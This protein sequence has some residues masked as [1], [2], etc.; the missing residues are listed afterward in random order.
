MLELLHTGNIK[1]LPKTNEVG[2]KAYN[3]FWMHQNKL[4]VP[5]FTV[6]TTSMVHKIVAPLKQELNSLFDKVELNSGKEL[7][8]ILQGFRAQILNLSIPDFITNDIA[9]NCNALFGENFRISVRSSAPI[10]DGENSSFAGQFDTYLNVSSQEINTSILRCIASFWNLSVITYRKSKNIFTSQFEFA[11]ILQEMIDSSSSGVAFSVNQHQNMADALIVAG[12]G[13]GEGVVTDK[14]DTDTYKVDRQS[15]NIAHEINS[16]SVMLSNGETGIIEQKVPEDK[17]LNQ[18]LNDEEIITAFEATLNAES[19]LGLPSDI[20]FC[21]DYEGKFHILQMRPITTINRENVIILDNTNIIESYPGLTLPLSYTFALKNYETVFKNSAKAFWLSKSKTEQLNP[22]FKD[23]LHLFNGQVY[24]RL[25]NWYRMISV[26]HKSKR[27]VKAWETAVGLKDSNE[28]KKKSNILGLLKMTLASLWMLINH[29]MRVKR[30][31]KSFNANY[32]KLRRFEALKNEPKALWNHYKFYTQKLFQQWYITIVNDFLA[33]KFFGLLQGAMKKFG[34]SSDGSLANDVITNHLK[35]ES[36]LAII[37]VLKLKYH[38][39]NNSELNQLFKSSPKEVLNE[40]TQNKHSA[41]YDKFK[42]HQD[43]YGDRTLSELKLETPSLRQKPETLIALIQTQLK[44]KITLQ[45]YLQN[46]D[47]IKIKAWK[48]IKSKSGFI[49]LKY[50][51]IKVLASLAASGLKN[52][53][54][55]RFS[56]TRAFGAIKEIF[57]EIGKHLKDKAIIEKAEDVFYLDIKDIETYCESGVLPTKLKYVE[58][59]K[60]QYEKYQNNSL[61][62]RVIYNQGDEPQFENISSFNLSSNEFSGLAVSKGII[63]SE[64]VVVSE[65]SFDIDVSGKIL[66]TRMTDPGWVFL[67]SQAA[68]IIS[69]KGSLLSHT[70]IIGR[71]LGIPVIVGLSNATRIFKSGQTITLDGNTGLVTV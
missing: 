38:I 70:A 8:L 19:I 24:Y 28:S 64:V 45:E 52:R 41:F 43:M 63:T 10:E 59:L 66:I 44:A 22:I 3:L 31:F 13:L 53:E 12:Y 68:G 58:D 17:K 27:S 25:D 71:E 60:I 54:N 35:V 21:F 29:P 32:Q 34:M 15:K 23:L 47:E 39:T 37:N 48:K 16:K 26:V 7:E 65:P 14:T 57:L 11:I 5:K 56:R 69:E 9:K 67:M 62:D 55:M 40:I 42:H 4:P 46:K 20:E 18:V 50:L 2:K 33:F 36:E 49:G 30:F 6:L 1:E 61:P 51:L